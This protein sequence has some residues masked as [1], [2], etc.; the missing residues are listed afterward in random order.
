MSVFE[1][2]KNGLLQ[3][4]TFEKERKAIRSHF[5]RSKKDIKDGRV[6][7]AEE[8]IESVA[9]ELISFSC[10]NENGRGRSQTTTGTKKNNKKSEKA[11]SQADFPKNPVISFS[12]LR[13]KTRKSRCESICFF[14]LV[15]MKRTCGAR[16]MKSPSAMK[17]AF[18]T[19]RNYM[20]ASL[21]TSDSSCFILAKPM[22]HFSLKKLIRKLQ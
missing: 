11:L 12:V 21:H 20:C 9:D 3:A 5:E 8:A 14:V 2:I 7:L 19:L 13:A 4:I 17:R 22:L 10:L 1:D 15:A 16:R 18:S 6:L